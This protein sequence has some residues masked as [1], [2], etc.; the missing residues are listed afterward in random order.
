MRYNLS[1][2][3]IEALVPLAIGAEM[4]PPAW[5]S[6]RQ[7]AKFWKITLV[8]MTDPIDSMVGLNDLVNQRSNRKFIKYKRN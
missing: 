1:S 7:P 3:A 6:P 4:E 8:I 2:K 5:L